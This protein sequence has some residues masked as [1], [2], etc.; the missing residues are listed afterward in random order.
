MTRKVKLQFVIFAVFALLAIAAGVIAR[1]RGEVIKYA[2]LH[3]E[4]VEWLIAREKENTKKLAEYKEKLDKEL[5]RE[6][7]GELIIVKK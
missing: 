4:K 7:L 3:P 5:K 6:V 2:I 1:S